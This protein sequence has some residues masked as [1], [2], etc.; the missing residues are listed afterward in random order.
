[1]ASIIIIYIIFIHPKVPTVAPTEFR[2]IDLL[3]VEPTLVVKLL[4]TH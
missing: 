3:I 2:Y 1:M 4:V